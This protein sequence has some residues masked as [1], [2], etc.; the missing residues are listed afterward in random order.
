MQRF[1]RQVLSQLLSPIPYF[2][3]PNLIKSD[4]VFL[5][6]WVFL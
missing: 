3:I 6:G 2:I 4:G 5:L 1:T